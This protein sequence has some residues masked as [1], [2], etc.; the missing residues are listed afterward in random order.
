M[1]NIKRHKSSAIYSVMHKMKK[2]D[3]ELKKANGAYKEANIK[4]VSVNSSQH[5]YDIEREIKVA[6]SIITLIFFSIFSY[7]KTKLMTII[8]LI[9]KISHHYQYPV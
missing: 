5:A 9:F 7:P 8:T 4:L 3:R 6:R 1:T 2:A